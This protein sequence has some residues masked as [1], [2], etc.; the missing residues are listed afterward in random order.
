MHW[1]TSFQRVG[2]RTSVLMS[3]GV[4]RVYCP[5]FSGCLP[6]AGETAGVTGFQ[7]AL[8]LVGLS[9]CVLSPLCMC[10]LHKLWQSQRGGTERPSPEEKWDQ[11][12]SPF[13]ADGGSSGCWD[14][15][16]G[17]QG[18]G[19]GAEEGGTGPQSPW[20]LLWTDG[21]ELVCADP[22]G[23]N[24]EC[25]ASLRTGPATH[26]VGEAQENSPSG[27]LWDL[28]GTRGCGWDFLRS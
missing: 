4:G 21:A 28:S 2:N 16:C 14:A 9:R 25:Q 12:W 20:W 17:S 18:L 7:P 19:A 22:G 23:G 13:T 11:K 26:G 6:G 24:L 5:G 15:A 8:G 10:L 27:L 3:G 1:G